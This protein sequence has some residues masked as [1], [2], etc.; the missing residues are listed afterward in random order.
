MPNFIDHVRAGASRGFLVAT[1]FLL[2]AAM[3]SGCAGGGAPTASIA[4]TPPPPP[5]PPTST[6]P[7][8]ET[9]ASTPYAVQYLAQ[10]GQNTYPDA[11][12][13]RR[14][15]AFTVT[16]DAATDT[17][18]LT[19]QRVTWS[20]DSGCVELLSAAQ[21]TFAPQDRVAGPEPTNYYYYGSTSAGP[22][23]TLLKDA[24]DNTRIVLSYLSYGVWNADAAH[25]IPFLT[26]SQTSAADTPR[27]GT[28]TYHG[29][30][31]GN[32]SG[33][34]LFDSSGVLTAD[35][36]TGSVTTSL[37][38]HANGLDGLLSGTGTIGAETS[39]FVGQL[40]GHF[41][42]WASGGLAAGGSFLG[43]FY[44]PGASEAGYAFTAYDFPFGDFVTVEGVF[45]GKRGP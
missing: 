28:G 36:A 15:G 29:I 43:G 40:T 13:P 7:P 2:A 23:L 3:L 18:V 44:G 8:P 41:D 11:Y 32:V 4:A 14:D 45:V 39:R 30:V 5:P 27:T 10:A 38:L 1:A 22:A 37:T 31:D 24:P 42:G 6:P 20:C 21:G 25:T 17:Y 26:G 19:S 35:F 34:R 33:E 9:Q 16:H 12:G